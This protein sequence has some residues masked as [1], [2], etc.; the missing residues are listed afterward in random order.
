MNQ[1]DKNKMNFKNGKNLL[2][3]EVILQKQ[4][5]FLRYAIRNPSL[6]QKINEFITLKLENGKIQIYVNNRVFITCV[7]LLLNIP[8]KDI[9]IYDEIDSIDEA[10]NLYQGYD[11]HDRMIPINNQLYIITPEQ[12]FWGHC[13]N[14]Q[15]WVEHDYDTR[16]LMS[17][18]SF[19]L[20]RELA[21]V[22]DR[23]AKKVYKEEIAIRLESGYPS[24]VEYLI[25]QRYIE[26][27]THYELKTIIESTDFIANI[28]L[29][30]KT[31]GRF[32]Q[33]ITR[34]FRSL[35]KEILI[36]ILSAP[37]GKQILISSLP[38]I[39]L[40]SFQTLSFVKKV[41][42]E[43]IYLIGIE[44]LKNQDDIVN[45]I[46]EID[47]ALKASVE[48]YIHYQLEKGV[49]EEEVYK[50]IMRKDEYISRNNVFR[51]NR[52]SRL[53]SSFLLQGKCSYCGRIMTKGTDICTWCGHPKNDEWGGSYPYI[54]NSKPPE[55]GGS[56]IKKLNLVEINR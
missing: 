20:L 48:S 55:G 44:N 12:E 50:C 39:S 18:L 41:K 14:I 53:Q 23:K 27:L 17:N 47:N 56:A 16:I 24:V 30:P 37:R 10:A 40:D 9:S 1:T 6:E 42:E 13:S 8:K 45:C 7:H 54:F 26:D 4:L 33:S 29:F 5:P 19:P 38:L 46:S 2:S 36:K 32:M 52:L 51:T 15:A 28:M 21:W 3:N 25:N 31:L 49:P 22:G 43:L 34:E 11:L 35:M